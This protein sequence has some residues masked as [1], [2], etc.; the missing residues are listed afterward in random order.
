LFAGQGSQRAGMGAELHAAS[1]VFAAAF[2]QACA[3]LET[4]LGVPVADVILGRGP[5][6]DAQADQTMFAQAG[7]FAVGAGLVALLAS[8]GITPSAVAGHSVGEVTAAYAAGVLSLGDACKLVAARAR[9]MQALPGGGTMTAIAA[10]EAEIT[11]ALQGV[12]GVSVAAVNGPSAVVISGDAETVDLVAAGFRAQGRRVRRLRVSHAFH[13]HRMEPVLDQLGQ[14]A[15]TLAYAAPRLPWACGLTGELVTACEPGYWVRQAREPVRFADAVATLAAQGVSVFIEIGPDGTLSALGPAVLPDGDDGAVFI[16]VLRPARPGP[17]AVVGALAQAH[18][19]GVAVDWAAILAGGQRTGLPTYAFQRQRYWPQPLDTP[20][21][22]RAMGGDGSGSAAEAWFWAAVEGGDL[23][24]LAATL[25]VDDEERLAQVLPVLASWRRRERDR[26]VTGGWRYR[27]SWAPVADP[28]PAL[29][30]GTW[31]VVLPAGMADG[32][33]ADWCAQ[34]MTARGA[35][36]VSAG[37]PAE[38]MG[39]AALAA[40]ISL[41]LPAEADRAGGTAMPPLAGVLSLLDLAEVPAAGFPGVPGGPAGTL[42]LVQALG[43]AGVG[44]PLWVLTRGAVAT[45]SSEVLASPVQAMVWGLGRVVALEHPARW[46]GLID[47]PPVLDER[48]AGRMCAVLAGCGEDQVAVRA[49]GLLGRRLVRAAAPAGRGRW[50]P[51]GT[52]LVTGGTGAI[53]GQVA[54]WLAGR[55]ARHVVLASR[56]GPGATGAAVLAARLAGAGARVTVSAC[57]LAE[58]SGLAALLAGIAAAGPPLSAVLHAAGAGQATAV[59]DTTAAELAAVAAAKAAG[60]VLLDELTAGLELEGFVLF[61]SISATWGS[62]LQP[63]YAAANA[64]LDAL[65]ENRRGRGLAGTSVAWGP[66]GG[67]GMTDA[68]GGAQLERRG[69]RLM[70]PGLAVRALGQVL[71]G[72]E[73]LVTV[74]DV[75]WARFAPAFTVR[76]PSPLIAGLPEVSQALAAADAA[77][78]AAAGAGDGLRQ[79]LAGLPPAEQ[80]QVIVDLVRGEA[81]AVLGHASAEA[82]EAGRAFKDLGFDSLT[83]VELRNQLNAATGLRLPA[84]LIFDYPTLTAL[85]DHVRTLIIDDGAAAPLPVLAELDKLESM[86]SAVAEE[87]TEAASIT[88]RLEAVMSKW[89]ETRERMGDITVAKKLESSTDDEV[90]DFIGKELGI[91]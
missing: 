62:G 91:F 81:A 82:V 33:L 35:Q 36:V 22:L 42:A 55:G 19:R 76:R 77:G 21:V 53:G 24:A 25:A 15:A 9:L 28:E 88:A 72:G 1:P 67:G 16:P 14:A 50:A 68:E 51:R 78:P 54:R 37:I 20:A 90:F 56:S 73:Q 17:A 13:S 40:R 57:D 89:K 38:D 43:D 2:D 66:W 5:T 31:L 47:L 41:A 83:A 6:P 49:A 7:L 18:V 26:S 60:A 69:L 39:R 46:G 52:V 29:L 59:A 10:T 8:C 58:R 71:D 85:A 74:A 61:S 11:T 75:D 3:L 12:A 45:G 65:A 48:A 87:S 64:F 63:G 79:Q 32:G 84:T 27:V 86:L 34:A 44:E 80:G 4:E 23:G 30:S 70:D